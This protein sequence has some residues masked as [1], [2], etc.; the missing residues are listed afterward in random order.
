MLGRTLRYQRTAQGRPNQRRTKPYSRQALCRA[1]CQSQPAARTASNSQTKSR[2]GPRASNTWRVMSPR[3]RGLPPPPRG[4]QQ[5]ALPVLLASLLQRLGACANLSGFEIRAQG[6]TSCLSLATL[7]FHG[8]PANRPTGQPV[9]QSWSCSTCAR[10]E[11][12]AHCLNC[13]PLAYKH[14]LGSLNVACSIGSGNGRHPLAGQLSTAR[15]RG[16]GTA[17]S[18]Q[19]GQLR[20]AGHSITFLSAELGVA[21]SDIFHT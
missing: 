15:C 3:C 7:P 21:T 11:A 9:Q 12:D 13:L 2:A 1:T 10:F 6:M 4:R 5:A 17:R 8:Q 14:M 19:R 16:G 20:A 18:A